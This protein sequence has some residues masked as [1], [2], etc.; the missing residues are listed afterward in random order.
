MFISKIYIVL[1]IKLRMYI[2][3]KTKN[4]VVIIDELMNILHRF[5]YV[6]VVQRAK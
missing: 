2:Y 1:T 5:K 4:W 3:D 6:S